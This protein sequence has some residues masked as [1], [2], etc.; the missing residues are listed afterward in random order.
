VLVCGRI[1]KGIY[2]NGNEKEGKLGRPHFP[3]DQP[4][5]G[6]CNAFYF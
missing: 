4:R 3:E 2:G 1:I 6:S 5:Y